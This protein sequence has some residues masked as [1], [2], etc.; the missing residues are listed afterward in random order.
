M[1]SIPSELRFKGNS[2]SWRLWERRQQTNNKEKR[3]THKKAETSSS[4]HNWEASVGFR[5]VRMLGV[6]EE[7]IRGNR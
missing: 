7:H 4:S 3:L 5:R 1:Q 2:T 6:S